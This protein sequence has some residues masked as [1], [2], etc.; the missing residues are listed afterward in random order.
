MTLEIARVKTSPLALRAHAWKLEQFAFNADVAVN[1]C[2]SKIRAAQLLEIRRRA[3]GVRS[4]SSP[5][6]FYFVLISREE[7]LKEIN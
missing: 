5:R 7:D 2:E 1:D 6:N 4:S 3:P